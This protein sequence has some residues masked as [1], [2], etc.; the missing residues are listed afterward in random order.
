MA[1]SARTCTHL[2]PQEHHDHVPDVDDVDNVDDE[3]QPECTT[4]SQEHDRQQCFCIAGNE[5]Q[6]K[7]CASSVPASHQNDS[8]GCC[9]QIRVH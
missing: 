3:D 4:A 1:R 5:S 6:V 8:F 2:L 7:V 9:C